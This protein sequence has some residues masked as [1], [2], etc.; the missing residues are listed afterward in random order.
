[1]AK[2][3]CVGHITLDTFLKVEQADVHCDIDSTN[4]VVCF[5]FGSKVPVD[6]VR[7]AAGG[8]AANISVG[9]SLLGH[10]PS[11][12]SILGKD[13]KSEDAISELKKAKVDLSNIQY[14]SN[15]TDQAA[16]I[17]YGS[18]RTIFTYSYP[19]EYRINNELA[20]EYKYIFISSIGDNVSGLYKDIIE[21]K[22]KDPEKIIFF[23]P[24]SREIKNSRE[25][26]L[27]FIEH[28]D[29]IIINVEE[30]CSILNPG[31][32]RNQIEIKDLL[33]LLGEKGP[34]NVVLTDAEN[35]AYIWAEGAYSHI[36]AKK[37]EVVEKTGAGDAFASGYASG[38]MKG[39]SVEEAA[40]FGVLNGSSVI[41]TTGAQNGLLNEKAMTDLLSLHQE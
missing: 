11:I 18:D 9:I 17:S 16:I 14:D 30:G 32:K 2:I 3:L 7:Y 34:N 26:I 39:L 1:M 4:C 8:G 40:E 37:V 28:V 6:E 35:G 23:N 10:D 12:Y 36:A 31:L 33:D 24:G 22:K 38:I 5:D 41:Q 27:T 21:A 13:R 15:P 19:R 20:S 29:H 25:D